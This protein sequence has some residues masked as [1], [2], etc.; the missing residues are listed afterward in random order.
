MVRAQVS[1]NPVYIIH[2]EGNDKGRTRNLH[3]NLLL[4][5]NNLPVELPPQLTKL[6]SVPTQ[7]P[8][9]VRVRAGNERDK[10]ADAET[11]DSD[12]E[13]QNG[14]WLRVQA[15]R[16]EP[17]TALTNKRPPISQRERNRDK[18]GRLKLRLRQSLH[19]WEA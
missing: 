12:D 7:K 19:C 5:V 18:E 4:L 9:N 2:P 11:S 14:Y 16:A 13:S 10:T 8:R 15:S 1:D 6:T 3:R 17:R